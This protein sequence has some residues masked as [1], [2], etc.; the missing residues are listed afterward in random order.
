MVSDPAVEAVAMR[1]TMEHERARGWQPEDVSGENRGFDVL[2]RSPDGSQVRFIE[3]KGRA[4][5]GQIALTANEYR[6]AQRLGRD[7]YLYVVFDCATSP[8][9]VVRRDPARLPWEE[10]VRVDHYVASA[11]VVEGVDEG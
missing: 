8:R 6:T 10:V 9:L 2:S 11:D 7:Y 5:T 3:V 1:V 4:G